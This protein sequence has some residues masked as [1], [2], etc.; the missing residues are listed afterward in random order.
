MFLVSAC[1]MG[2]PC[3]YNAVIQKPAPALDAVLRAAVPVCPEILGGLGIPR[4]PSE[5]RGGAG[6]DVLSGS[7]R[8][9]NVLGEDVTGKHIDGAWKALHIGLQSGCR[10]AILKARSPSCGAGFIYDGTFTHTQIFG[11]GVFAALLRSQGFRV[12][13][14]EQL[15]EALGHLGTDTER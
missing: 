8:V 4:L 14:E 10:V 13:T 15:D 5:V 11:D 3:R 6:R 12:Y 2:F 7:A 9:L 1:L